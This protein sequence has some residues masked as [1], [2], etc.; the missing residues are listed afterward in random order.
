MTHEFN[1]GALLWPLSVEHFLAE[2][3]ERKPLLLKRGDSTYYDSLLTI[4]HLERYVSRGGARYPEIR[5]AK[6]GGFYAP[7]AY[8]HDVKYGD[9]IFRG[10]P[11][12]EKIFTEYSSGATVTLPALHLASAPLGRLCRQLETELDHSVHANAYLTPATAA[13]FTPHYDTH[14]VFALQIAGA[15]HWRI[16]PPPTELPHR[17][18]PFSPERY[19]LPSTPL[20]EC[21][22]A[23]GD[24][25]YLPR[26]YV[27]TTATAERFSAHLTIGIAVYTWIDM[28]SEVVQ[29]ALEMPELRRAL[30]PGFAHRAEVRRELAQ[31]L[32]EL[33][34]RMRVALDAQAAGERFA[35]KVRSARPRAPMEFRA[36]ACVIG[37]DTPLRIA[38][39]NDYR[40]SRERDGVVLHLNGRRVRL[41]P[42][43]APILDAVC[44][45][46]SF[47]PRT[48]CSDVSLDARIALARYLHG[49]GFLRGVA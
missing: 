37:P 15:K 48:L 3:W 14:E 1:F 22:L 32:P 38:E 12:V 47:T 42:A 36:D 24:L 43:V 5:L 21:D 16:Y 28:L 46:A 6:G 17:S 25:L 39:D 20:M 30:P 40:L 49:L 7:E 34:D 41:H 13:G 33:F 4:A 9:E 23:A 8:T 19:T 10:L 2:Y 18:Q 11:D 27:H 45:A 31:R 44:Q 29:T 26:G 35:A